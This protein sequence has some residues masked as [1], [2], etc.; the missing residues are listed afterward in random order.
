MAEFNKPL[1]PGNQGYT[2]ASFEKRTAAWVG[3]FYML[4]LTAAMTYMISTGTVLTGIAPLLL[5]PA[6]VGAAVI[7]IHRAR[8][9]SGSSN[10]AFTFGMFFLCVFAFLIGLALG[11]PTLLANFGIMVDSVV[12]TLA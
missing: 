3:V 12:V 7:L 2:P 4:M 11:I 1:G 8:N 6:A 5:P 10:R 9:G